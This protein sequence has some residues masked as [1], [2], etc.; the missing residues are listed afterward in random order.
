L[1]RLDKAVSDISGTSKN[2]SRTMIESGEVLVNERVC[3]KP[4][5]RVSESDQ[6]VVTSEKTTPQLRPD[7]VNRK[8]G[9][10]NFIE[11]VHE[12]DALL[13][14]NKP[15]E[16]HSVRIDSSD[17]ITVADCIAAID[18]AFKIASPSELEAG[19]VNRLDYYTSGIIVGSKSREAWSS[20]SSQFKTETVEKTY[21]ALTEGKPK[22]G[23]FSCQIKLEKDRTKVKTFSLGDS[24]AKI[25]SGDKILPSVLRV[26]S[27]K[28]FGR[29][30]LVQV[31]A[32]HLVRH[33]LRAIL[34][35][36]GFPLVGDS[37]YGSKISLGR[38]RE[39]GFLDAENRDGF[40]LVCQKVRFNHP[41][42]GKKVEFNLP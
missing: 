38:A 42:S 6:V 21:L 36:N 34:S 29:F 25:K 2:K 27:V 31:S 35:H 37:L 9:Y 11:I 18:E 13:I 17:E 15:S 8:K 1:K 40:Y 28:D 24:T 39:E 16:I 32:R 23:E 41:L 30:S 4:G 14:I 5:F 20:L 3:K 22:T 7:L 33:Q 10:E 26:E 12:D 19:L